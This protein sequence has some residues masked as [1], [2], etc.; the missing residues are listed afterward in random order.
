MSQTVTVLLFPFTFINILIIKKS[1]K[2]V[3]PSSDVKPLLSF[4]L[5]ITSFGGI[6]RQLK[7]I[8]LYK[9]AQ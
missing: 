8:T 7:L 4:F 1:E 3:V 6:G 9:L 2:T 5:V